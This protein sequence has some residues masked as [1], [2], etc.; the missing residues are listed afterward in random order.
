MQKFYLVF[1]WWW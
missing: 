1:C